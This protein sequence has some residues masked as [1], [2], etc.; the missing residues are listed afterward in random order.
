MRTDGQSEQQENSDLREIGALHEAGHH[1]G[2]DD[3]HANERE[4]AD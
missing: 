2:H 4:Q 1:G 3:H